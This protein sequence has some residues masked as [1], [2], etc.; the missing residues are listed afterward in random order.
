MIMMLSLGVKSHSIR[1]S[2]M[3]EDWNYHF[4]NDEFIDDEDWNYHFYGNMEVFL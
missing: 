3:T 4:Y 2:R 1:S